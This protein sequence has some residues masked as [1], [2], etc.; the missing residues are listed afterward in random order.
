[1]NP[2]TRTCRGNRPARHVQYGLSLIE[3]MVA[4]TISLLVV[5]ALSNLYL[6]ISRTNNEMAK[7]NSQVE[8]GRF[9]IQLLQSDVS[10]AGFWG[11][12]VPQFDDLSIGT[13][14]PKDAPTAVPDPCLAFLSWDAAYKSNLIGIP[15]QAYDA[16]PSTCGTTLLPNKVADT[17]V[18]VVRHAETCAA[19][20]SNCTAAAAGTLYFQASLCASENAGAAQAATSTTITLDA[21]ASS[22]DNAYNG[23]TVRTLTGTGGGQSSVITAYSGSTKVATVAPAWTTTPA[24]ATA[25]SIAY[26]LATGG[27]NLKKRDCATVAEKRRFVSN[28]YYIRDYANTVGDG[29]PALVRSA[30]DPASGTPAHQSPTTLIEGIESF[31]VELGIDSLG[32]SGAAV[33]HAAAIAWADPNTKTTPTNR[34]DG[35]PDAD[36]VHCTTASPCTA[37]QLTDVVGVKLYVLARS[38]ESTP[39]YTDNKTYTLGG[40][41]YTPASAVSGYKR[42]LFSTAVRL[43]NVSGRRE[44]P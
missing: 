17:D 6:N 27:H 15:L 20:D 18:L 25:Y 16:I 32:K 4:I 40:T 38:R 9:A 26:T 12:Y 44:T 8:N 36:Y 41:T 24:N 35:I 33:N 3:L 37:A 21:G 10:H 2:K 42:H 1:M 13:A 7:T 31:R 39:G 14:T 43:F 23:M 11:A 5:L 30:F 34:G 28:I 22:V 19:G 29:V